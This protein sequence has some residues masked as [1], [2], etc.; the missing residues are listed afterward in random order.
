[1]RR[2]EFTNNDP[3]LL[4]SILTESKVGHLAYQRG[5][6]IELLP[7]NF[8]YLDGDLYFHC[9]PRAGLAG[10]RGQLVK[11]L[12][13]QKV[14]WIPSSWRHPELACPATTYFCSV[15]LSG[16]MHEVVETASKAA[17]LEAFMHKYQEEPYKPLNAREY[18]KPLTSLFVGKLKIESPTV[19]C[20]MGQHLTGGQ[21][22]KVLQN[23]RLRAKP[24]DRRVAQAMRMVNADLADHEWVEDLT[25]AQTS[26]LA[27]QLSVT[28]WAEGR[29]PLQQQELNLQSHLILAKCEGDRVLCFARITN[30][31]PSNGYLADVIVRNGRRGQGLGRELL[32]RMLNHPRVTRLKRLTL[33][34]RDQQSFYGHFGFTEFY[35]TDSSFMVREFKQAN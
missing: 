33:F 23:L 32:K 25:S 35:R 19:K 29:T 22:A 11:F 8:A 34:T 12:A 1:M 27:D 4:Q 15:T 14:S 9:S 13:Y 2:T 28:Y 10:A 18:E 31:S 21:R 20:K 16:T 6:E 5:D 7:Y 3:A 17:A 24:E 26:D 30:M